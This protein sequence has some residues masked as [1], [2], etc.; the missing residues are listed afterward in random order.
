MQTHTHTDDPHRINFKNQVRAAG[1]H[2]PGLIINHT[3]QHYSITYTL[4]NYTI[5]QQQQQQQQQ[6]AIIRTNITHNKHTL[7]GSQRPSPMA[8]PFKLI[9]RL[10]EG[11]A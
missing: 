4:C 7:I 1:R 9:L 6:H 10:A 3:I 2:A 8:T 11:F 5:Q